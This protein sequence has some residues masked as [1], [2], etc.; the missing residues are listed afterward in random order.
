MS[1]TADDVFD[2][3]FAEQREMRELLSQ[4]TR[5]LIVQCLLGHPHHLASL[6]E[7][8]YMIQKNEGAVL[9][10]LETLQEAGLLDV[11]VHEPNISTRDLPSRFWGPTERGVDVLYEH[12]F[13][14]GV[15]VA[16]AVYEETNK[17]E[18]VRRHETAPRPSLPDAVREALQFE[19]PVPEEIE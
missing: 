17:S 9:D 11:Y 19:E 2:D 7:L 4:E 5:H 13:L 16:R 8:T 1:H 10:Q 3:P 18:K 14:R 6:A 15:P 12:N